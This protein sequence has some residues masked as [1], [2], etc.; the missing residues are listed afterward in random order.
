MALLGNYSVFLKMPVFSIAGS[1]TS[2]QTQLRPNFLHSGRMRNCFYRDMET[3]AFSLWAQPTG[4]YPPY[5]FLPPQV[6][7]ELSSINQANGAG[8]LEASGAMGLNATAGLTGAGDITSAV[9]QLVVSLVADLAGSGTVSS[10]DLRAYLNAV[11]DLTGG[12]TASAAIGALAWATAAVDGGGTISSATPYATGTLSA[13]ILSY[14]DMT[15]EGVRDAVWNAI[16]ANYITA[17]SAGVALAS[18]SSAGDP[19]NTLLPG[20]YAAGTAGDIIGNL[21][22]SIGARLVENGLSQDEVTRIM[23]SAIKGTTTG[24]GTTTETF[25]SDDGA[26]TRITATYDANGNRLTVATDGT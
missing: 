24:V 23:F 10:A 26:K 1:T 12:G 21:L 16:L 14:S 25:A 17:G 9:G 19:W 4:Y 22:D 5:A 20:S 3:A 8:S 2:A 18:A 6:A 13:T 15:A 7:G 11:A